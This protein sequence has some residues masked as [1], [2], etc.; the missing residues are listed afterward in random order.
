MALYGSILPKY[1]IIIDTVLSK[2]EY[3]AHNK[4]KR[5]QCNAYIEKSN[6]KKLFL[7]IFNYL[8]LLF[9][10]KNFLI[11][12]INQESQLLIRYLYNVLYNFICCTISYIIIPPIKLICCVIYFYFPI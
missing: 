12:I 8:L 9:E 10:V 11:L 7:I 3:S 1:Y 2:Y 6:L 5:N 4:D